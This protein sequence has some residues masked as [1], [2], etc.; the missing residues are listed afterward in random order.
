MLWKG[1]TIVMRATGDV[2]VVSS[3]SCLSRF[4]MLSSEQLVIWKDDAMNVSQFFVTKCF[5]RKQ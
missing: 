5:H 4:E 2:L 3:L 1:A